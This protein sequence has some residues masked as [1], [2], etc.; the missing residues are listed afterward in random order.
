[1]KTIFYI[2]KKSKLIIILNHESLIF[3]FGKYG[4]NL[5]LG[6]RE[7]EGM[8][9]RGEKG[10]RAKCYIQTHIQ[11]DIHTDPLIILVDLYASLTRFFLLPG[12]TFPEVDPDPAI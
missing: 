12:S 2:F 5:K 10:R 1:M 8:G 9:G 11:T 7:G 4:G 6:G 3:C